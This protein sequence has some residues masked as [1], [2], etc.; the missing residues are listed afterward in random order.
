M[1]VIDNCCSNGI[2]LCDV[3]EYNEVEE[4]YYENGGGYFIKYS[5]GQFSHGSAQGEEVL[6]DYF[7]INKLKNEI[8]EYH[9]LSS[10]EK[11]ILNELF[12][13]ILNQSKD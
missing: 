7:G 8:N 1:R 9:S 11:I 10:D 5:N 6:D 13:K 2:L 3:D 12:R 4:I